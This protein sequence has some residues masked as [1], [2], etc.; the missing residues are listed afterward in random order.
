MDA[1]LTIK[2]DK[3]VID[4]AKDYASSHKRSLSRLIESYLKSL[5][6]QENSDENDE[7]QISPFVK[8]ISS[9]INIPADLDYK[10]EYS[11]YLTEKYK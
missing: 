11:N 4:R 7:I 8:D 5:V 10:K 6:I 3:Y 1:K 2:L 9:G